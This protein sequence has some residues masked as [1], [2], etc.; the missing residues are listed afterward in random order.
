MAEISAK[1]VKDLRDKT[2]VGMMECKKALQETDGD[3]EKAVEFL[4]KRGAAMAAKRA[5]RE[6]KEGVIAVKT[7]EDSRNGVIVEV[8]CETD[9][10][11]R[12][13]DFTK[14]AEAI[15]EIALA[16]FPENK[17]ALLALSMGDDYQGQ[18]VE[19]AIEAMTGKIGEKIEISKVGVITSNDSVVTAYVH[20]GAKLATLVEIGPAST[21]EVEDLSKDVAMQIAAAAPLVVDRSA[22][23]QEKLAQ[24]AEIY[25]QQALREG[26]PE[27][28]VE[29][30]V[31]GR[32]EKYYQDVVLLEQAF[33][34]DSS[35]TVSDVVKETSKRLNKT[36]EIRCFLRYQLGE[37]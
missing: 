27:K 11:A 28:F 29:K 33:I 3:M 9:F 15:S 4:R 36:I 12:G 30:I 18:T 5:D 23:P 34:K 31:T 37:K 35:K 26:K 22:V 6:A 1:A 7:T 21:D 13:E 17:E 24:E 10:V 8:N 32:I 14:F 16:N 19:Q 25:K 2:G 20:P